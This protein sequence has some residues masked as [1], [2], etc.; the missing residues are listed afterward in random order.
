MG[1][2]ATLDGSRGRRL[3]RRRPRPA[4]LARARRCPAGRRTSRWSI[5][6]H[7]PLY[8]YYPPWNFWVRDWREVH[9]ILKPYT[10]RHQHPRPYP[11]GALQRDRR[12]CARSACSPPPGP[13]PTPPEGVPALTKPMIRVDPGDHFDGVGWGKLAIDADEQ[14]RLRV[15]D[16]A[17][18]RLRRRPRSI[19][20]PATTTTR[21]CSA[22]GSLTGR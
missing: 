6:T 14:G 7:N 15:H 20:A 4:R 19:R 11:P 2:M 3:G 17:Q 18:G 16:V 1:H 9:E 13:G 8:E 21:S 12:R 22:R 10:Q 5:F